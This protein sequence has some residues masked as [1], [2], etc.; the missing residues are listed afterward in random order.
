[1]T[2][3]RRIATTAVVFSLLL[4]ACTPQ[5]LAELFDLTDLRTSDNPTTQAAGNAAEALD[6]D[7]EAQQL[8]AEGLREKS[9]EKLEQAADK[10]PLDPLYKMYQAA[11]EVADGNRDGAARKITEAVEIVGSDIPGTWDLWTREQQDRFY[12]HQAR[13]FLENGLFALDQAIAIERERDP[14]EPERVERLEREF[15][16]AY[17]SYIDNH[18]DTQRRTILLLFVGGVD[19]ETT[20]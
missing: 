1:M 2:R 13:R 14:I 8:V 10:R 20:S 4:A 16:G 15:C 7:R 17:Q 9:P 3:N 19:C 11:S 12:R 5:E 6:K 18:S